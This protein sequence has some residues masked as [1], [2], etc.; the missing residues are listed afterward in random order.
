MATALFAK[1]FGVGAHADQF[2]DTGSFIVPDQ[3]EVSFDVAF[4]VIGPVAGKRMRVD[5][6]CA[7]SL[8]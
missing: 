6:G 1:Q 2:D 8:S 4:H 7:Y 5:S 3:Q